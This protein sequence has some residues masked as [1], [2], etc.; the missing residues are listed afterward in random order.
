MT[1]TVWQTTGNFLV[2][3]YNDSLFVKI[4]PD[5]TVTTSDQQPQNDDEIF[6]FERQDK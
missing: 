5:G 1:G 4:S 6:A 3:K 2:V